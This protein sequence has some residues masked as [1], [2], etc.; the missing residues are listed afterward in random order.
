MP[1]TKP[2][3]QQ[4]DVSKEGCKGFADE[5]RWMSKWLNVHVAV[6]QFAECR[7]RK[8]QRVSVTL[9][10]GTGWLPNSV[11]ALQAWRRET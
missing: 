7:S 9:V 11:L 4:C 8:D 5:A 10:A 6:I 3:R 2:G 1:L